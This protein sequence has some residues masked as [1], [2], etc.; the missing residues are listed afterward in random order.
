[1][2]SDACACLQ[3]GC[4]LGKQPYREIAS[5]E[6]DCCS[7][8]EAM[9]PSVPEKCDL[10]VVVA[11]TSATVLVALVALDPI[12][13][14]PTRMRTIPPFRHPSPMWFGSRES[15]PSG[16]LGDYRVISRLNSGIRM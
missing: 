11:P 2:D 8:A 16:T 13:M 3:Q 12:P 14:K 15:E 4:P 5:S 6:I 10:A 9:R 7:I 1:M